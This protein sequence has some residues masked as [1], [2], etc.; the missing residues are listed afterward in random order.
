MLIPIFIALLALLLASR[1]AE[2][3]EHGATSFPGGADDFLVAAMPPPG[4]YG[5]AYANGYRAR[6][7]AV[8]L[9]VSAIALRLDWV[10]PVTLFGADRWGTLLAVP[11]L[12]IDLVVRPA[13]ALADR[14]RGA[15]DLTLGN[16]LHWTFES[17]H[18]MLAVDV[19]APT[20]AYDAG[21][22]A[23]LGRNQ[24]VLRLNHM[25]TWFP[26]ERWDVSYRIHTDINFRNPATGYR[27]GRTAYLGLAA[28]WKPAPA[29]TIGLS[30]YFLRQ[31]SDDTIDG[32]RVGPDGNRLAVRGVG[33]AV[34]HFFANGAFVTASFYKESG[35]RNTTRGE[36]LWI[37]AGT[38]F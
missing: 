5:M 35:A 20:G 11:L 34:K 25:G 14:R 24:W 15:G 30:S 13:P 16:A 17:Y 31:L 27:S 10:K 12:D 7:D 8:D 4:F 19:V 22:L 26:A 1:S 21:R 2:A 33:P 6:E 32:V 36:S 9:S 18:A 3:T 38:R 23:N 37:Y 28:G 29:T